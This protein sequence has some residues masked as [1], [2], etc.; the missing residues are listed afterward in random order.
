MFRQELTKV[1]NELS[2]YAKHM[3]HHKQEKWKPHKTKLFGKES[4][5]VEHGQPQSL[6]T[7]KQVLCDMVTIIRNICLV[8][9]PITDR[10][11]KTPGIS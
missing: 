1:K 10:A 8:F 11:L 7:P 6:H 5:D 9:F 2:G 4:H 3:K